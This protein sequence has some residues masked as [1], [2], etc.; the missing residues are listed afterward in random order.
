MPVGHGPQP[1]ATRDGGHPRSRLRLWLAE[2]RNPRPHLGGDRRGS[3]RH[4]ALAG[5]LEDVGG[6]DSPDLAPHRRRAGPARARCDPDSP[7]VFH[8]DG[9]PVRRWRT[10]WRTACQVAWRA[11]PLPPRLPPHRRP[12]PAPHQRPR[13][14]RHA[15]DRP[16][17]PHHLRPLQH[18]PR[19]G[20][21]RRREPA[22]RLPGAWRVRP[23][24]IARRGPAVG[25]TWGGA[26]ARRP[27]L[28]T[29]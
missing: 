18:H 26:G 25:M 28:I 1:P 21:A 14:G 27:R 20:T 7:L 2:K 23:R 10:T 17:E 24:Q 13:A 22:R 12:H 29:E 3:R 19:A 9:I 6:V 4:P 8:R 15:P 5:P 16:Q 11:D